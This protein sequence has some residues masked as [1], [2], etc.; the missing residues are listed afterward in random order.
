MTP[1]EAGEEI[2]RC[3]NYITS[4]YAQNIDEISELNAQQEDLLHAIELNPLTYPVDF[5]Y[6]KELKAVREER[7]KCKDANEI[8]HFLY[9]FL[10]G[11]TAGSFITGLTTNIGKAKR[12]ESQLQDRKYKPRSKA[13]QPPEQQVVDG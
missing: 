3:V 9:E 10:T 12:R 6:I 7:R 11:G 8:A 4:V 13:F 2:L 1:I 5:R